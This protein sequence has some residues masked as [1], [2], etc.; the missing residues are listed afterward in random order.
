MLGAMTKWLLI[1][2]ACATGCGPAAADTAPSG[3]QCTPG[4][5]KRGVGCACPVGY[6]TRLDKDGIATCTRLP[7]ECERA[8]G[9]VVRAYGADLAHDELARFRAVFGDLVRKH[10]EVDPWSKEARRCL[11]NAMREE[12]TFDC[13]ERLPVDQRAKLDLDAANGFPAGVEIGKSELRLRTPIV[14]APNAATVANPAALGELAKVLRSSRAPYVEIQVHVDKSG[15]A[16]ARALTKARAE[17]VR[18]LLIKAGVAADRLVAKGYGDTQPVASSSTAW[19]RARN[20]RV[21]FVVLVAAPS[22][23]DRD[24]DGI[25]DANDRC[26]DAAETV[27]GFD[28]TDGCPDTMSS[29]KSEGCSDG[30]REA[31]QDGAQ[32]PDIAACGARWPMNSLRGPGTD[33][34]SCGGDVECV[35]PADAC[36][37]GWHVCGVSG[38][39]EIRYRLSGRECA[40]LSAGAFVMA[41]GDQQCETCGTGGGNGATCCGAGCVQQSGACIWPGQTAWFGVVD[42][43]VQAC[44]EIE[45]RWRTDRYGVMCCRD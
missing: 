13:L 11:A 17:G 1:V 2:I 20:R 7:S 40:N 32:F 9:S 12:V 34:P 41:M 3:Y 15:G 44:G 38:A 43:H 23:T 18:E 4:T 24:G 30:T 19:A 36:Q 22:A 25:V 39:N 37:K 31:L 21:Q 33:Q 10:C 26:P 16:N 5:P 6:S 35:S 14:F 42:G 45:M 8:V 28:D 29:A 27:N